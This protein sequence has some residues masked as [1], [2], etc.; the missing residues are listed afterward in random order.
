MLDDRLIGR[1]TVTNFD[2]HTITVIMLWIYFHHLCIIHRPP[3]L[4][5]G[6]A[7]QRAAS[8]SVQSTGRQA[9]RKWDAPT[10]IR[11]VPWWDRGRCLI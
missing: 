10:I 9:L 5:L 8:S 2:A 3:L 6:G 1:R 4:I 11:R 7:A